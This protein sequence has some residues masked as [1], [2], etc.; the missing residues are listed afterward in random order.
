MNKRLARFPFA[1]IP[2]IL[3]A[4][5]PSGAPSITSDRIHFEVNTISLG[6]ASTALRA[7][8]LI[9]SPDG[10]HVGYVAGEVASPLFPDPAP[11]W[12]PL[13]MMMAAPKATVSVV[14]DGARGPAFPG[15]GIP[16]FSPDGQRVAYTARTKGLLGTYGER[17]VVDGVQGR[18][19][20]AA[21]GHPVFSPDGRHVAFR[22]RDVDEQ[23]PEPGPFRKLV[24]DGSEKKVDGQ[25]GTDP[26][27]SPD[28]QRVAYIA[29]Q[30][31]KLASVVNGSV[32]TL[33]P[34]KSF[35]DPTFSPDGQR[36]AFKIQRVRQFLV[37]IDGKE[38]PLYDHIGPLGFSPDGRLA[39]A[40]SRGPASYTVVEGSPVE[41]H[42][43]YKQ[44]GDPVFSPDGKR[45]A[46]WAYDGKA[47]VVIADGIPGRSYDEVGRLAFGPDGRHLAFEARTGTTWRLVVDGVQGPEYV[48]VRGFPLERDWR[49]LYRNGWRFQQPDLLT[50][51]GV[52]DGEIVRSEAHIQ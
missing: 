42:P 2:A 3:T 37:I 44:V 20:Y 11:P 6:K 23:W 21:V 49:Q 27:F 43:G 30:R 32:V 35:G 7:E 24:T 16:V 15:V 18:K 5:P 38:G 13:T 34:A 41:E 33:V 51:V 52:R 22:A 9:V 50:Y 4:E 47:E 39:Y 17:V 1:L 14:V 26:I 45:V 48:P 46:Y 31:E 10:K 36:L 25:I 28:S 40:A 29:W 8:S 19:A 12:L